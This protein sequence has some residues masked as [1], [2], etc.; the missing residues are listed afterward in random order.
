MK[1]TEAPKQIL[2]LQTMIFQGK[3]QDYICRKL[4]LYARFNFEPW[5]TK[6]SYMEHFLYQNVLSLTFSIHLISWTE[7]LWKRVSAKVQRFSKLLMVNWLIWLN[8]LSLFRK[9]NLYF[10]GFWAIILKAFMIP[11]FQKFVEVFE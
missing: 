6:M 1:F 3:T 7:I 9:V 4:R 5:N 11:I 2:L 8:R 10:P